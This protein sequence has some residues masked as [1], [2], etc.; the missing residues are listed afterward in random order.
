MRIAIAGAAGL[1][2][3]LAAQ[4]LAFGLAGAGHG[5]VDPFFFTLPLVVLYPA[6]LIR[7]RGPSRG[8]G[9][10]DLLLLLTGLALDFLL[11]GRSLGEEGAYLLRIWQFEPAAV[12]IWIILWAGWQ[13][14]L[15]GRVLRAAAPE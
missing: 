11:V 4:A 7:W 1:L 5:W 3:W 8:R 13:A 2:L 6:A 9:G 10:I 12:A 15:L 14:A